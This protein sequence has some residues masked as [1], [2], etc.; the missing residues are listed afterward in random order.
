LPGLLDAWSQPLPPKPA[1]PAPVYQLKV[2]LK[3]AKPPI[4]R[5][6]EVPADVSLDR[7]HVIIQVAFGWDGS[8]LHVF[9]TPFGDFGIADPELHHRPADEVSLAQALPG[10]RS[11]ISYLY[12]FGDSWR[13]EIV[14]EKVLTPDES[15]TYPRC[16][17]GRRATPPEDCGGIWSYAD[18]LD[19]LADPTHPEHDSTLEWLGLESATEFDPSAFDAAAITKALTNLP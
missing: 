3:D 10:E 7:L 4:W 16:T 15:V 13:H 9:E 1:G 18:M 2:G 6:L 17:G 8:H 19:V 14:V 11:K 5:R 12:D